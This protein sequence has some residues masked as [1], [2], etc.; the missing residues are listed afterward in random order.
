MPRIT[1][2]LPLAFVALVASGAAIASVP[3]PAAAQIPAATAAT[4]PRHPSSG[5]DRRHPSSGG[6]RR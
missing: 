4:H 1:A 5:G 3:G 2:R 6:D